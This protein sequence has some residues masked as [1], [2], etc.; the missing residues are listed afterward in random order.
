MSALDG[1]GFW[2]LGASSSPQ[3][4]PLKLLIFCRLRFC[5][6]ANTVNPPIQSLPLIATFKLI[7]S[8]CVKVQDGKGRRWSVDYTNRQRCQLDRRKGVLFARP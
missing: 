5:P 3:A 4:G 7:N 2:N 6:L 8:I 1:A